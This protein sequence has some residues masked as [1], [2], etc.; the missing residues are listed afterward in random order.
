MVDVPL[1]H[2]AGVSTGHWRKVVQLCG[3]EICDSGL[4]PELH[5]NFLPPLTQAAERH[6]QPA[7][8]EGVCVCV[9]HD[10]ARM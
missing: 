7:G 4:R 9:W 1:L 6:H 5:H 10:V 3:P 8:H 2:A